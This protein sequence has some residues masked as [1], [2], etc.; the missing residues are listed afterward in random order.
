MLTRS[1]FTGELGYEIFC[2]QSS[3]TEI[4]DAIIAAGEE[5]GITPMGNEA[6]EMKRIEAGLMSAGGEFTPDADAFE[7]GLGFA[8]DMKKEAF[9]GR[10]A[11]ARNMNAQKKVLVGLKTEGSEVPSHN[12]PLFVGRQHVGVITSATYSPALECTIM[13]ARIAIEYSEAGSII[14]I[15]CLDGRI[16]RIPSTVCAM[17]FIDPKRERARA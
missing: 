16:K 14:E 15:G 1:G 17:P 4:W 8:V 9:I 7:A 13:M 3:A 2:D 11:L 12:T 5:F 10:E 6:L